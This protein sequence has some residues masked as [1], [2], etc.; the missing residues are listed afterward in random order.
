MNHAGRFLGHMFLVLV[1]AHSKW[2]MSILCPP[3]LLLKPLKLGVIFAAHR[4]PR[5]VV[6]DNGPSYSREEFNTSMYHYGIAN[7]TATPYRPSSNGLAE[8]AVQTF[9][10]G[11]KNTQGASIQERLSKSYWLHTGLHP[12]K[13]AVFH[14]PPCSLDVIYGLT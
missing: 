13:Q 14:P 11:L 6:T 7:G 8:R 1:D 12:R 4:I 3:L 10:Q 9:K 5:T 2:M